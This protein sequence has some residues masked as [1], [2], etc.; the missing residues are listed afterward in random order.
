MRERDIKMFKVAAA[1]NVSHST[2]YRYLKQRAR[3][4]PL[5]VLMLCE[6]LDAEPEALVQSN[7]LLLTDTREH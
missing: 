7:G 4:S 1:L 6:L 5:Q 2:V 3:L